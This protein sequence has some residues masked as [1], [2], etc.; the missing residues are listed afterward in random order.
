VANIDISSGDQYLIA[1]HE[2]GYISLWD[3]GTMEEVYRSQIST[4]TI[5]GIAFN[6]TGDK[7]V[8]GSWAG[9]ISIRNTQ[10]GNEILH[11]TGHPGGTIKTIFSP[12]D[13][14]IISSG[15]DNTIRIW[16]AQTGK[17]VKSFQAH[18]QVA[19]GLAI[20]SDGQTILSGGRDGTLKLWDLESGY[21]LYSFEGHHDGVQSVAFSPDSLSAISGSRDDHLRFW[22][23]PPSGNELVKWAETERFVSKFTCAERELYQ[24]T[25]L[26]SGG[27]SGF[28]ETNLSLEDKLLLANRYYNHGINS[29]YQDDVSAVDSFQKAIELNPEFDMAYLGIARA[30]YSQ[31]KYEDAIYYS[32]IASKINQFPAFASFI[33]GDSYCQLD[34]YKKCIEALSRSIEIDP[35]AVDAHFYVGGEAYFIR[36]N[37]HYSLGEYSEAIKDFKEF[38]NIVPSW[39]YLYDDVENRIG[40]SYYHLDDFQKAI[41]SF[42]GQINKVPNS[43]SGYDDRGYVYYQ[44]REYELAVKDLEMAIQINPK[45]AYD[46][47]F[48]RLAMSYYYLG[49][50]EKC[51]EYLLKLLELGQYS[52][53][54]Y[55]HV[56]KIYY[57]L[58]EYG[59]AIES[60]SKALELQ[61]NHPEALRFMG[62]SYYQLDEYPLAVEHFS[63]SID[64]DPKVGAAYDGLGWTYYWME[65]YQNAI[66]IFARGVENAPGYK[67]LDGLYDGLG[68]SYYMLGDYEK[69][70]EQFNEALKI[71]PKYS[72]ALD[73]LGRALYRNGDA[74][75]AKAIFDHFIELY[76]GQAEKYSWVGWSYY[77]LE[78]NDLAIEYLEKAAKINPRLSSV[79]RRLGDVYYESGQK[80]ESLKNYQKYIS[81]VKEPEA[82]VLD[83]IEE[84]QK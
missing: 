11:L 34:Q 30:K 3:L 56:G 40:W 64:A 82:K 14:L 74:V 67:S 12:D 15:F 77:Y 65:D 73:G 66:K 27:N 29:L 21:E 70:I 54:S 2:F 4:D 33:A 23:V 39:Y 25:P 50:L 79:Y 52:A 13:K 28:L 48:E 57:W 35:L 76:N 18:T 38:R 71:S 84:L 80:Q 55:T 59:K 63:R 68:W 19:V 26:C 75:Q 41:E 53:D 47:N 72:D 32:E 16:D 37:A 44:M 60:L 46:T 45:K 61:T 62:W 6:S 83:R 10:T 9:E 31:E 5:L 42:S 20:S 51:N 17:L 24:I 8:T 58:D 1:G 78:N 49:N 22:F 69:A 43:A 81:L 36:G 7:Y